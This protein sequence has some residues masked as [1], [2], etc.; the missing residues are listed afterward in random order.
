MTD[1]LSREECRQALRRLM[2]LHLS[3]ASFD[4]AT[5]EAVVPIL[6]TFE[7][8]SSGLQH[9]I[10]IKEDVEAIQRMAQDSKAIK[11]CSD[12]KAILELKALGWIEDS[13]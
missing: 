11:G 3:L 10:D 5:A 1:I 8:L 2:Q 6:A 12:C 4:V 9:L 7:A 13:P